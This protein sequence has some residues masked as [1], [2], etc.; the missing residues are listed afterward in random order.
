VAAKPAIGRISLF[1]VH[2]GTFKPMIG[3]RHPPPADTS[4]ADHSLLNSST[5]CD[6]VKFLLMHSL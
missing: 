2:F 1:Y 3:E 6:P 4:S 5:S